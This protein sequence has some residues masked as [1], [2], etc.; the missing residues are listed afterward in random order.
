MRTALRLAVV[1]LCA[2]LPLA[3]QSPK[4][5]PPVSYVCPMSEHVQV[6]EDVPGKC[7][8]CAMALVPVRID[9][10]WACPNHPAVIA[11]RTGV[12]L[13][14]KRDLMPVVVSLYWTCPLGAGGSRYFFSSGF[15]Y[16]AGST[17]SG[18]MRT[19][20]YFIGVSIVS[21]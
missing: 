21:H 15:T 6:L 18:S 16:P 19:T 12:C 10:A 4:D 14:D 17:L 11:D 9:Q 20:T 5:L 2:S 13:L 8:I 3:A 1:V 7:P